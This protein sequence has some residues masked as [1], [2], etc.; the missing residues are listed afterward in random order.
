[1]GHQRSNM[2]Q[3]LARQLLYLLLHHSGPPK[4]DSLIGF[5]DWTKMADMKGSPSEGR[6]Q[7]SP[8]LHPPTS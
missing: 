5:I 1:M 6:K 2:G 8:T 4:E 3:S 7:A